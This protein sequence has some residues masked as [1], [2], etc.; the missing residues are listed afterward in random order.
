[1]TR[2][3]VIAKLQKQGFAA[4]PGRVRQALQNGYLRPLPRKTARRASNYTSRHLAQLRWYFVSIR[5]GP[6]PLC[7]ENFPIRGP[8]DR[9]RRLAKEKQRLRDRGPPATVLRRQRRREADALI[10]VLERIAGEL[11]H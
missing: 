11:A 10:E 8:H 2:S 4:S 1:M 3:E 9:L 6:S 5:P 7:A